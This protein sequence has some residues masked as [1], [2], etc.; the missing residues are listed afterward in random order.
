MF[1][2]SDR[3]LLFT[4]R[5]VGELQTQLSMDDQLLL[6]RNDMHCPPL[7]GPYRLA[8]VN[9]NAQRL[10][11]ARRIL[12]SGASWRGRK[13]VWFTTSPL[14]GDSVERV[15]FVF[16]GLEQRF[17]P[18]LEDVAAHFHLACPDV[19]GAEQSVRQHSIALLSTGQL[20]DA[21]LR[22]IGVEPAAVAGH[23]IGEW[24]AMVSAGMM[25]TESLDSF[26]VGASPEVF[27][28]PNCVFAA[29]GAGVEVAEE[30][31]AG[32]E[33]AVVSH[34]NCPHQSIICGEQAAIAIAI[35]RL[36]DRGVPAR[37]LNFRSGFHSPFLLPYLEWVS[38]IAKL[39][40]EPA[41]VPLWSATTARPFP[42]DEKAIRELIIRHLLEP[43]R[44]RALIEN[45]YAAGIRAFVQVGVGSVT[46]FV[47][48]TL[49]GREYTA[50]AANVAG[51]PGMRQLYRIAAALWVEGAQPQFD[52]LAVRET[53]TEVMADQIVA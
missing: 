15:A 21:A 9:A 46:S 12:E 29:L 37:L 40:L 24:N 39:P 38:E 52:Q 4:G 27:D 6:E 30:A 49:A 33:G 5:S 22:R 41:S 14:I 17:D 36:G 44:F 34:D 11:L 23:S 19:K 20:L 51:Q 8:I 48:D 13:D 2:P 43:V 1:P 42:E 50:I 16:P 45:L 26:I 3:L 53:G 18:A 32:I 31:I 28:L 25:S 10:A 35:K 47:D 7:G